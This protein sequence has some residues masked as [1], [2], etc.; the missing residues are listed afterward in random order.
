ML[1]AA[2]LGGANRDGGRTWKG[3][4]TGGN[5]MELS[6]KLGKADRYFWIFAVGFFLNQL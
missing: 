2:W 4:V 3:G 5:R 6:E 1:E